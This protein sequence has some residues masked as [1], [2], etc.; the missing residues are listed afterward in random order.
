MVL[1]FR[2]IHEI[3][4]PKPGGNVL[5]IDKIFV[6]HVRKGYEDRETFI[7]DQF[8]KLGIEFEFIL[9]GD[10]D[11]LSDSVIK[12]YFTE[13]M[14]DRLPAMSC[15]MKHI[16]AHERIVSDDLQN[17]LILEDDVVLAPNF[18][19]VFNQA[20]DEVKTL[21]DPAC[22]YYSNACNM[23]VPASDI[24]K[25]RVLY[26][27]DRSRAAD[28]YSISQY[29]TKKRLEFIMN[30]KCT[31]PIDHQ[32]NHMDPIIGIVPY[33]CHP[34]IVEQ[35]SMNGMFDSAIDFSRKN[36]FFRKLDWS[37]QKMYKKHIRRFLPK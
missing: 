16:L 1:V 9:D 7:V 36:S 32:F 29:V 17:A 24:R 22:I 10:I 34:T 33:W 8:G 4:N 37:L 5:N 13:A 26:R 27:A 6:L 15:A 30:H 28:S 21:K 11:D 35:G 25:G 2:S 20:M 18:E 31:H 19:T 14:H 23:Y 12:T 3:G